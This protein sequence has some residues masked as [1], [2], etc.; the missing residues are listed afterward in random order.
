MIG[1]LFWLITGICLLLAGRHK[2]NWLQGLGIIIILG[3]PWLLGLFG[4]PS[5][6]TLGLAA[7]LRQRHAIT[8]PLALWFWVGG[9]LLYASALGFISI[10]LYAAGDAPRVL[11]VWLGLGLLL[12]ARAQHLPL[13]LAWMLGLALRW[14]GLLESSNLWNIILDPLAWVALLFARSAWSWRAEIKTAGGSLKPF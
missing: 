9:G 3:S 11:L 8:L 10:D 6:A 5:L 13:I 12:A 7:G 1:L 14:A 4:T 2:N